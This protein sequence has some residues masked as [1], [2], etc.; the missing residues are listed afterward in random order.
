MARD[1]IAL[2]SLTVNNLGTFQ[3]INETCL[4]TRYNPNWYR[5]SL[6]QGQ[7][8]QLAYY[9]ELPVGAVKAKPINTAYKNPTHETSLQ[10]IINSK[11][12]PNAI[13]IESLSVL[14]AYRNLGIGKKLVDYVV[15]ETK[16]KFI[17][18]I[19]LHVHVDNKQAIDFYLKQGFKQNEVVKDYYKEQQL[20]N[21]DAVIL[22]L[23][24]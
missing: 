22:S 3:K 9:T 18:E 5:D 24:V 23:S 2:D 14:K 15:E 12:V 11:I 1:I 10:A 17:H 21:P 20:P 6:D 19:V 16:K 7:I 8:V 13:Y 4:P